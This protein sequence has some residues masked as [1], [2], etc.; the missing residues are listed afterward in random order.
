MKNI[1]ICYGKE[2]HMTKSNISY[3]ELL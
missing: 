3:E 1:K 2:I